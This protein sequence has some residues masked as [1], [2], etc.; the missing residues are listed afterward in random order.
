MPG[1]GQAGQQRRVRCMSVP[2]GRG[3]F[4]EP[5]MGH[6]FAPVQQATGDAS[7]QGGR[8]PTSRERERRKERP[9]PS[10]TLPVR[11]I[12]YSRRLETGHARG[13]GGFDA[14][15]SERPCVPPPRA[16]LAPR[17]WRWPPRP[18]ACRREGR[19]WRHRPDPDQHHHRI[20]R[21]ARSSLHGALKRFDQD[22]RGKGGQFVVL[23][24]FNPEGRR[25]ECD[26]FGACYNLATY[27]AGLPT[28][29]KG[30]FTV[31]YVHGDVR[32]HS[33]LPVLACK[34]IVFS[35]TGA[36]RAGGRPGQD[37]QPG[38]AD[39]LRGDR[40]QPPADRGR[41]QDVGAVRRV[42]RRAGAVRLH[43]GEQ[44]RPVPAPGRGDARR[45]R[46]SPTACRAPA[47]ADRS[48]AR[49]PGASPSRGRSPARRS[50][51]RA[52]A[53]PGP[54]APAPR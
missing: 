16:W 46:A 27:L 35:A 43:P 7:E 2:R 10:P 54:S 29:T 53:W 28:E 31:A 14:P 18:C 41:P 26:D 36:A 9:N 24:D 42:R 52:A 5:S 38:R 22:G 48:T 12:R 32:R 21:P 11:I 45:G 15:D 8:G 50:R 13:R 4:A 19:R 3:S 6:H 33:V 20:R 30:V 23:C 37:A 49:W 40:P 17:S 34:E 25:C 47:S 39:R 51:R 44:A 1:S